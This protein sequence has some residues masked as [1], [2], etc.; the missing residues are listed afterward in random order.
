MRVRT[1]LLS[2]RSNPSLVQPDRIPTHH[3][4]D[5]EV[6]GGIVTLDVVVP[7]VIDLL[8]GHGQQRRI[9]LQDVLGL[10][11]Q[12]FALAVVDLAIDLGYEGL[13]GRIRPLRV[14]LRSILAVP[15]I[16]VI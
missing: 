15:G 14:V 1:A 4:V 9:L 2:Y 12:G 7:A 11:N 5:P 13:E 3:V 6:V 10:M 16:E 8:P